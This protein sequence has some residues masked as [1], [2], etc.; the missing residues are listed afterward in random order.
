MSMLPVYDG[1]IMYFSLLKVETSVIYET[2]FYLCRRDCGRP[3]NSHSNFNNPVDCHAGYD[4]RH[5]GIGGCAT[6]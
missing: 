4:S 5:V 6:D 2:V 3:Y 1:R